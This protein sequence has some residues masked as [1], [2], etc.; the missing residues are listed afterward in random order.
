MLSQFNS[1][2]QLL[3]PTVIVPIIIFI[4]AICLKVNFKTAFQC[5][6]YA[7]VGLTGFTWIIAA[8]T[9]IVTK[10]IQQ[11]VSSLGVHL[12]I[13]DIGWQAGSLASFGSP[14]GLSF[15]IGGF[16][17]ELIL[18]AIGVTK[19]FMPS[20]LWNNFGFMI[21]G[22]MAYFVTHNFWLSI[23]LCVFILLSDLVIGEMQADRWS[24]YF[25]ID[26]TTVCSAQ[27]IENA[28]PAILLDPLWNLIGLNKL[29]VT[30]EYFRKRLGIFGEPT[31]L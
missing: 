16:V 19:I 21:W 17:L 9:P 1:I 27:N 13:V 2:F 18:F 7:G 5:G 8:F 24:R 3:G 29:H 15:F 11:M 31:F 23:G 12:P 26:N 20:N 28:V 25:G 22:T 10:V 30:P 14:V 6:L 4:V